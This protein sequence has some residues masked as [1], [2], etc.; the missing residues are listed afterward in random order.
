M[1]TRNENED[2]YALGDESNSDTIKDVFSSAT[3]YLIS[4]PS[5][6]LL[7]EW[8]KFNR[9]TGGVRPYEY[10]ILCG[11]TGVGKT[12]WLSNVGLQLSMQ[13]I[14]HFVA[15]VETGQFD[16]VNRLIS[17][18]AK[19]DLNDGDPVP[20]GKLKGIINGPLESLKLNETT[21]VSRYDNRFSVEQLMSDIWWH[22]DKHGIKVAMIDNLNFFLEV[23]SAQQTVVEMDRVTHE[24][25]MFCKRVPVHIIM[26]MHPKKTD[27]GRVMSE[28]DIKGSS[29]AVQEAHNV[30]LLNRIGKDLVEANPNQ[31]NP[32]DRELYVAKCRRRGK[33]V[34]SRLQYISLDGVSYDEGLVF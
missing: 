23:T 4:P 25:I 6:T 13:E 12:T 2:R 16:W 21:F 30:L 15:S 9:I 14:P 19:E 26:V 17:V 5:A 24:L 20:V 8:D 31:V 33:F 29:T 1:T 32:K 27:H 22:V 11:A 18:G 10:T 28:F 34:G 7:P 3:S